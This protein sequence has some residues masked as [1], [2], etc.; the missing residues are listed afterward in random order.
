MFDLL[1]GKETKNLKHS[2]AV[3]S[4]CEQRLWKLR[5]S[6]RYFALYFTG[7]SFAI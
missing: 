4:I 7:A 5:Y 1:N 2:L 3:I 6:I